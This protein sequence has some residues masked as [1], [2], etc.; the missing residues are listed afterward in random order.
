VYSV[1]L[2]SNLVLQG[3]KDAELALDIQKREIAAT[4][5]VNHMGNVVSKAMPMITSVV[6]A[7]DLNTNQDQ[8]EF[9]AEKTQKHSD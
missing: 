1:H 9:V 4:Q 8:N 2:K 5:L 3:Q 6:I 7:G